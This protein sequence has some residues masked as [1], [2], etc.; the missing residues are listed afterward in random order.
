MSS[1][2][3]HQQDKNA[4]PIIA[5][6]EA[7]GATYVQIDQP[8]DGILCYRGVT[9]LVEIKQPKGKLRPNQEKFLKE[10]PGL[11]WVVRSEADARFVLASMAAARM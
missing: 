6:W 1:Y 2:L 11:S 10:W 9:A 8:V 4:K 7:H 5:L 3:V